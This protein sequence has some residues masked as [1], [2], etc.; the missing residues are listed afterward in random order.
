MTSQCLSKTINV[1]CRPIFAFISD[2]SDIS[3]IFR[4]L[5]DIIR[6]HCFSFS[7]RRI[8]LKKK[9]TRYRAIRK[10]LGLYLTLPPKRI[11]LLYDCTN[12][13]VMRVHS[14]QNDQMTF[15]IRFIAWRLA[16]THPQIFP[17]RWTTKLVSRESIH[18]RNLYLHD[19][20]TPVLL[21]SCWDGQIAGWCFL[22]YLSI[23]STHW[24]IQI[25]TG[26][27]ASTLSLSLSLSLSLFYIAPW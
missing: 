24:C 21:Q 15:L 19:F 11:H 25:F 16:S 17:R 12:N 8:A 26:F 23:H 27:D 4:H 7:N 14:F 20:T 1:C 13:P 5:T 3:D 6:H 2:T 10:Y 9:E 22:L 18:G